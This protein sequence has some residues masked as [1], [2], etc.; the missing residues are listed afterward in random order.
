MRLQT[1]PCP[2]HLSITARTST[3]RPGS[4]RSAPA[5]GIILHMAS[6]WVSVGEEKGHSVLTVRLWQPPVKLRF[7]ISDVRKRSRI[8]VTSSLLRSGGAGVDT[9]LPHPHP[10]PPVSW[11]P[12]LFCRTLLLLLCNAWTLTTYYMCVCVWSTFFFFLFFINMKQFQVYNIVISHL[13]TLW[14]NTT[15]SLLSPYK[16]TAVFWSIFIWIHYISSKV[17]FRKRVSDTSFGD[18]AVFH[19]MVSCSLGILS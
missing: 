10:H 8:Q 3:L 15:I 13:Y 19:N 16:I 14:I 6:V 9:P 2:T 17:H 7:L 18:V 5:L 1:R 11:C 4:L 12:V